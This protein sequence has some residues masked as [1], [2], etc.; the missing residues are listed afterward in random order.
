M[1]RYPFKRDRAINYIALGENPAENALHKWKDAERFFNAVSDPAL[2]DYAVIRLEAAR[3]HYESV[4]AQQKI[5]Q[6]GPEA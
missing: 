3:K 4:V 1:R 2:V 6:F 5:K